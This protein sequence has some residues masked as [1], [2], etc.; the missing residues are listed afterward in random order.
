[1]QCRADI[2]GKA[3]KFVSIYSRFV[4]HPFVKKLTEFC[5]RK[6]AKISESGLVFNSRT[7][8]YDCR[9]FIKRRLAAGQETCP[10][11]RSAG[12]TSIRLVEYILT[13]TCIDPSDASFP[14]SFTPPVIYLIL[15]PSDCKG[16]DYPT[17]LSI[18]CFNP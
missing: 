16:F 1:M 15:F 18:T 5:I 12:N 14:I 3:G 17:P 13:S 11:R 10:S 8:V 7:S 9:Q 6:F 2:Q 4:F